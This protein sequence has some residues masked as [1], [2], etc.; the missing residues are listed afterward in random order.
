[1]GGGALLAAPPPSAGLPYTNAPLAAR[2]PRPRLAMHRAR[3]ETHVSPSLPL[4]NQLPKSLPL[5]VAVPP[6]SL[7]V[8]RGST[9]SWSSD[10]PWRPLQ[11]VRWGTRL[12]T[13]FASALR[14]FLRTTGPRSL[15]ERAPR[16]RTLLCVST[17]TPPI[18]S[19]GKTPTPRHHPQ[20]P[21]QRTHT[22][23]V[24]PLVPGSTTCCSWRR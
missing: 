4:K 21:S 22:T 8:I 23:P 5:P 15:L 6:I 1:V 12:V 18:Y 10:S 7:P 19:R 9:G 14:L 20:I 3:I 2:L 11:V 13:L 17:R 16:R 24:K